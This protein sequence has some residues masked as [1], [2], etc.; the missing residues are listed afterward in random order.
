MSVSIRQWAIRYSVVVFALLGL[1]C[2]QAVAGQS[3]TDHDH[4][5][6]TALA[7][8]HYIEAGRSRPIIYDFMDPNCPYCHRLYQ[9][10]QKPIQ[11][12]KLRVR[13]IVVG[14]LTPSSRPK[15]ATILSATH[16]LVALQKNEAGFSMTARGP[17]GGITPA[18]ASV[19]A[20]VRNALDFNTSRLSGKESELLG[21]GG[22]GVPFLVWRSGTKLH[23]VYGPPSESQWKMLLQAS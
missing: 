14:V 7:H 19:I 21:L 17:E 12:G 6:W 13:F 22:A 20:S 23:Y 15:A 3:A 4:Y 18:T 11:E 2:G 9:R 1:S 8:A 5:Y 16:P 10:L